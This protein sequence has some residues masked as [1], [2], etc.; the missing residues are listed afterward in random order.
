MK[1]YSYFKKGCLYLR[2]AKIRMQT[3]GKEKEG[4]NSDDSDIWVSEGEEANITLDNDDIYGYNSAE[5]SG[6][7]RNLS[8]QSLKRK[9]AKQ[10]YL[11]GIT[12][13][14]ERSLQQGF[15]DGYPIGSQIGEVIGQL[16]VKTYTRL[17]V[18]KI[19]E[20]DQ[21]KCLKEL[22][23]GNVLQSKYFDKSL[24]IA[25]PRKHPIIEHWIH[26]LANN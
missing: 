25:D 1:W 23:I 14:R 13:A 10:G 8:V 11:D 15:D 3:D 12:E 18:N 26:E 2:K 20:E 6:T 5:D 24:S 7:N 22:E 21:K 19:T 9:H 17:E 4:E 16:I